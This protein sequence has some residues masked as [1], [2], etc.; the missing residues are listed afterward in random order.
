M[1]AGRGSYGLDDRSIVQ[2]IQIPFDQQGG[3]LQR[4]DAELDDFADP[5]RYGLQARQRLGSNRHQA[6]ESPLRV[7]RAPATD[8]RLEPP[9]YLFG[10]LE[11]PEITCPGPDT[12]PTR[13]PR[14]LAS[15]ACDIFARVISRGS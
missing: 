3:D 11:S 10:H 12:S 7:S 13:A 4:F 1:L 6:L 9:A 15:R 5:S 8:G 2:A 14:F